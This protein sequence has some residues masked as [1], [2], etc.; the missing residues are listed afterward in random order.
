MKP[1]MPLLNG[2]A[3]KKTEKSPQQ[4]GVNL[5]RTGLAIGTVVILSVLLSIQHVLPS[6]VALKLYDKA[7]ENIYAHKTVR[8]KDVVETER[9][10]DR[11]AES[12]AKVYK[13]L[14]KADDQA[15]NAL[16]TIFRIIEDIR[17]D[18]A[19]LSLKSQV[20]EARQK[21]R[22]FL[23]APVADSTF[24]EI[25]TAKRDDLRSIEGYSYR[26]L[27]LET[28]K[29]IRNDTSDLAVVHNS[30]IEDAKKLTSDAGMAAA[31]GEIV[32]AVV[33]P[34]MLYDADKTT[35]EQVRARNS[36]PM[37]YGLVMNGE[38]IIRQGDTVFEEHIAKFEALGLTNPKM[39]YQAVTSLSLFVIVVVVLM[40]V[41]LK[42]YH[43]DVYENTHTL[44]LLSLLVIFSTLALRI[45]GSI[46]GIKFSPEQVGY[47]G[48]LWVVTAGM[49]ITVLV[50]RQVAVLIVSLLSIVLSLMVNYELGY[51]ASALLMAFTG[52]YSIANIRDRNDSVRAMGLL[53]AIGLLLTWITGGIHN[54]SLSQMLIGSVWSLFV[55]VAATCLFWF[56]TYILERPFGTATHIS[57]LELADTNKPL[58]KRLVIE[59]P[60]TFTHSMAV[61]HLAETAAEAIGAD[62]LVSRVGSY[63]HDIG[64]INRPHFFIENQCVENVHDRM[65]PTLSTLVITSHIKDGMDVAKEHKLP[66]VVT[67]V[68]AQH[69]G[70][71]LVQYFYSQFA[72]E[73]DPSTALEQQFRYAGPKPQTKETAIV[74]LADSVEAASRAMAKPTPAKIELLVNRVV[75]DKLRDGQ[76]DECELTFRELS[77]ITTSF[78]RA[79]TGTMHA[80]I[81]YPDAPSVEN[82]RAAGNGN[83]D[84][85]LTKET[86]GSQTD[87]KPDE[88]TAAS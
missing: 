63:Y 80:R 64:K 66:K 70:T 27:S 3:K 85:E 24:S 58:L 72:E 31:V 69:H 36:V 23:N 62:P 38:L 68:I 45:G 83:S 14:V 19:D 88:A 28:K 49:F 47:L 41:Y 57:L 4:T 7:P 51:A 17:I 21:A 77:K 55:A 56:G 5:Q 12:V 46:L 9:R 76:L 10:R 79:L 78:V 20:A 44:L 6:K 34:N 18:K 16:K 65:N 1:H 81:E 2:G 32:R 84:S 22:P 11:A 87:S 48:I 39:D 75:A 53:A 54:D 73:H 40:A 50:S 13:P 30:I 71:S 35:E 61:G 59:A 82:K 74:M 33:K 26:L 25:I 37:A 52:I 29:E 43:S 42:R 86:S 8:Y 60:G 15:V 67:D